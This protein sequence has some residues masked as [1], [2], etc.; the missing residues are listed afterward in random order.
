MSPV[1]SAFRTRCRMFPSLVNCCTIDWFT[2]WPPEALLSVSQSAFAEVDLGT[3][4][5]KVGSTCN[6]VSLRPPLSSESIYAVKFK[7]LRT[8]FPHSIV[9]NVFIAIMNFCSK[10][11]F[12]SLYGKCSCSIQLLLPAI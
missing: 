1:G 2:E 6:V 9:L 5:L 12:Y 7:C 8:I 10:N 11:N 4:E 3:D